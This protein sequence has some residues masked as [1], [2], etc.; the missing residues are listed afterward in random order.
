MAIANEHWE[1]SVAFDP[2]VPKLPPGLPA[3]VLADVLDYINEHLSDPIG[4]A[5]LAKTAN[6]SRFHFTKLFKMST[7]CSPMVYLERLRIRRAQELIRSGEMRLADVALATGFA[8]QS[9]FTRRF[10]RHTG[11]TPGYFRRAC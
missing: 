3:R 5:E 8:D 10:H 6:V 11:Y 1:G 9:H 4:L 2:P 7:G